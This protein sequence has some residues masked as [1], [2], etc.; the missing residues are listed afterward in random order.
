MKENF[1][2]TTPKGLECV[3]ESEI[4]AIGGESPKSSSGGVFFSGNLKTCYRANLESRTATR[5]L[6]EVKSGF[7]KTED[8]IYRLAKSVEWE[9]FFTNHQTFKISTQA[10]RCPLK[11]LN[12][13]TLKVKDA[14]CDRF[15][16]KTGTRPNVESVEPN[17]RI[18]IFL[19]HNRA[20]LYLD[21]SGVPLFARGLR[22]KSVLAPV[23]ENL[24]AGILKRLNWDAQTP[25]F[26]PMCGSATFLMEA[27]MMAG[28]IA[29]GLRRNFAFQQWRD[30]KQDVWEN[31][32]SAAQKKIK[33][34]ENL[35]IFGSDIDHSAIFSA[36]HNLKNAGFLQF[37]T[38]KTANILDIAKPC[39][40]GL[41]LTNP[42]YGERLSA[43]DLEF[44]QKL[45]CVLKTNFSQW[46]C[47]FLSADL[48]FPRHLRLQAQQK[49]PLFNGALDCRVFVFPM[50]AGSNRQK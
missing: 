44:L 10:V 42:P 5:I 23:K 41:L 4:A 50:V 19:T 32:K 43:L 45:S 8:D 24:A 28:N 38:L 12:F 30:F 33:I 27:I 1:F 13:I 7:Y 47:A 48:N 14:V 26:D 6:R 21:S 49:I 17:V 3:L 34:P 15:R 11:S 36:R 39:D 16:Q 20:T 40:S 18:A 25:F 29:P 37:V 46:N 31:L 35:K 2:A 22:Q 9:H